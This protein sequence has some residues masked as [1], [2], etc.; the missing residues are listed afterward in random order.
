MKVIKRLPKN[1][2]H[3]QLA[4]VGNKIS[5]VIVRARPTQRIPFVLHIAHNV[6]RTVLW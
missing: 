3:S 1:V 6:S 4:N 5:H 2:A